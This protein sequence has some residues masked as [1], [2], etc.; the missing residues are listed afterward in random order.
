MSREKVESEGGSHLS[1]TQ[2]P[3][4]SG[5]RL[6]LILSFFESTVTSCLCKFLGLDPVLAVEWGEE[7]EHPLS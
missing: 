5:M 6:L 3:C 1:F 4:L 7:A 2:I